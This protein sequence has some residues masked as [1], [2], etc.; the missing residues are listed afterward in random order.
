MD[1]VAEN[2]IFISHCLYEWVMLLSMIRGYDI[3]FD[4]KAA[5][6]SSTGHCAAFFSATIRPAMISKHSSFRWKVCK[7]W[8]TH[9]ML[10]CRTEVLVTGMRKLTMANCISP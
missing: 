5:R 4:K 3:L 2:L 7:E 6:I 9:Q 1:K 10:K 8:L